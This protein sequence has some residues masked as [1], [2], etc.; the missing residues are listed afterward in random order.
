MSIRGHTGWSVCSGTINRGCPKAAS[1]V[2]TKYFYPWPQQ[3]PV[4]FS[5]HFCYLSTAFLVQRMDW[6]LPHFFSSEN[7]D[8]KMLKKTWIALITAFKQCGIS[9]SWK[10][11]DPV[12]KMMIAEHRLIRAFLTS[13]HHALRSFL[14]GCVR[15][16]SNTT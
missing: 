9:L 4:I 2:M 13:N 1:T 3:R 14:R 7:S 12:S 6:R 11:Y 5:L 8:L 16:H 10:Y 15:G